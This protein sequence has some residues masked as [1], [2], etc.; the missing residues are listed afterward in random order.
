MK[1]FKR[2]RDL[3]AS[4]EKARLN[5]SELEAELKAVCTHPAEAHTEYLWEHDSGYGRLT[6]KYGKQCVY[7]GKVDLW[8]RGQ[9]AERYVHSE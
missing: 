2:E 3:Y 9:F 4:I 7:C 1:P 8:C 5:L 6:R